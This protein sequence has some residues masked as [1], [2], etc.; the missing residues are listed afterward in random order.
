DR[1]QRSGTVPEGLRP[2]RDGLHFEVDHASRQRRKANPASPPK[3]RRLSGG[4]PWAP[5]PWFD[6]KNRMVR[7]LPAGY[8]PGRK[9]RR[10]VMMTATQAP[11]T[12]DPEAAWAAVVA[13]DARFDGQFVCAVSSTG[14]YCRPSCPSRQPRRA[15]VRFF[16]TP[17]EAE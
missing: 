6:R 11:H 1:R 3:P 8:S 5:V 13:R 17:E 9:E 12:L 16:A 7:P 2:R 10:I 4:A 14:I 15:N